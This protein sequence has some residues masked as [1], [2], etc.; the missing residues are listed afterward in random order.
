MLSR[1][2][3]P[4]LLNADAWLQPAGCSGLPCSFIHASARLLHLHH[5]P[6]GPSLIL[7]SLSLSY[8]RASH[9]ASGRAHEDGDSN[10]HPTTSDTFFS[11]KKS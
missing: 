7:F 5:R 2:A 8:H 6:S 3:G 9:A 1:E 10:F 11:K 4:A